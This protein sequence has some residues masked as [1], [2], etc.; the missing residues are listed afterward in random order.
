MFAE[1]IKSQL[2]EDMIYAQR[3]HAPFTGSKH[4]PLRLVAV[5]YALRLCR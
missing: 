4:K 2:D 1:R 5:E 3:M